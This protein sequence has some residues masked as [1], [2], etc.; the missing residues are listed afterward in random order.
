[1]TDFLDYLYTAFFYSFLA[2]I[3]AKYI[4]DLFQT[5]CYRYSIVGTIYIQYSPTAMHHAFNVLCIPNCVDLYVS[6]WWF[7]IVFL[8]IAV[9]FLFCN[10][11]IPQK[12][13]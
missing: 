6:G 5:H 7:C 4:Y 13:F 9:K 8:A 10:D 12:A 1:M 11:S 2:R 3:Y